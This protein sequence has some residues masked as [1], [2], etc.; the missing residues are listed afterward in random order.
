MLSLATVR[1]CHH[2]TPRPSQSRRSH[3]GKSST[4]RNGH[5][6]RVRGPE[7]LTGRFHLETYQTP[8]ASSAGTGPC[9]WP[10]G[11]PRS[12]LWTFPW[13]GTEA[14]TTG[15]SPCR[16]A[17]QAMHVG[18]VP[19]QAEPALGQKGRRAG[20]E[21]GPPRPEFAL[22][23]PGQLPR[24]RAFPRTEL[25]LHP[26]CLDCVLVQHCLT[27]AQRACPEHRHKRGSEGEGSGGRGPPVLGLRAHAH[28]HVTSSPADA[29]DKAGRIPVPR[30]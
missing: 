18:R 26:G 27:A 13:P 10:T 12:L 22:G 21:A 24:V 14:V 19:R 3:P 30:A 5:P 9:A 2:S 6:C 11:P 8:R 25:P 15:L 1:D 4:K 29:R 17:H 16:V 28:G 7:A 23:P 20:T